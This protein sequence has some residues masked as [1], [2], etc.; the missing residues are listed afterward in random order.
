[1]NTGHCDSFGVE[2]VAMLAAPTF[3]PPAF[4]TA[5]HGSTDHGSCSVAVASNAAASGTAAG[6]AV[7]V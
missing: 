4:A 5:W 2:G 6:V 3:N 1:M 7:G